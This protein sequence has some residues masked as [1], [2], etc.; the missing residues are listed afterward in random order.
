MHRGILKR[1][2]SITRTFGLLVYGFYANHY[3][4]DWPFTY[5]HWSDTMYKRKCIK[6]IDSPGRRQYPFRIPVSSMDTCVLCGYLVSLLRGMSSAC[7]LS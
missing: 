6:D 2:L 5:T 3:K 7:H 1:S 4:G